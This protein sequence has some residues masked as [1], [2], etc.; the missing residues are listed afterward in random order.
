M[1]FY[2]PDHGETKEDAHEFDTSNKSSLR[3]SDGLC[4]WDAEDVADF[5]FNH[6]DGWEWT[7]PIVIVLIND[8]GQERAFEVS[9]EMTPSFT[10]RPAGDI[11]E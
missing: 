1:K 7:W 2:V 6:H 11:P 10:A 9:M 8:E 5:C 4:D 3:L